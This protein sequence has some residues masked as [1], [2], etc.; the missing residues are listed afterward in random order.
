MNKRKNEY[1]LKN[2]ENKK[3]KYNRKYY[4]I[5]KIQL[6]IRKILS[7]NKYNNLF[8]KKAQKLIQNAKYVNNTTLLGEDIKNINIIYFYT[9]KE[10]NNYYFFDIRELVK[11]L[12][13]KK[14]NPYTNN[15]IDFKYI[16]QIYRIFYKLKKQGI[17]TK[18]SNK[19]PMKSRNTIYITYFIQKLNDNNLYTTV[20]QFNYLDMFDCFFIITN[21]LMY[22]NCDYSIYE[23]QDY[24]NNN[25]KL[26]CK[27]YMIDIID[28]IL[29]CNINNSDIIYL[30][31][32]NLIDSITTNI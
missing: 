11:H 26:N 8:D 10:N 28:N 3:I 21:L 14:T 27:L 6:F 20:E 31:I 4:Y 24:F 1:Y 12:K 22:N 2:I 32:G 30:T 17:K 16:K 29:E 7:I 5:I 23:I 13:N 9:Y 18:I 19:I 25:T 15:M